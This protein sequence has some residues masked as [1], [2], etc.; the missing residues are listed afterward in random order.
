MRA[1]MRSAAKLS[2]GAAQRIIDGAPADSRVALT[3]RALYAAFKAR[4]TER[5]RRAPLDLDLP[6]RKII[7]GADGQVARVEKR[8]R[9]DA[10]RLI[11]EFMI[12]ANIAAAETLEERRVA[13][14]YRV[15]DVPDAEKLGALREYLADLG[16]SLAAAGSVRPANF[17][18]ILK[19][20][21][22]RG[23]KEMISE[24]V[25]R[26][27]KQAIYA[28]DNVGHFGLNIPR[29]AHFTSPIRRYADLTVHRALVRAMR[30]G[31][32]AQTEAEAARLPS[33]AEKISDFERRAM[34]A[35]RESA[36]RYLA[37]YHSTRIGA[38]FD[39][40]IRGVTRFGLF[41][42]LDE[43]GADGFVP[44]AALGAERFRF[45][46]ARHSLIGERTGGV[47]RLGQPVRVRLSSAAPLT[48]GLRFEMVSD[49]F[50]GA[51]AAR[52]KG[53]QGPQRRRSGRRKTMRG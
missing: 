47:Y 53:A 42:A 46:E 23:E 14:I 36:D 49:P 20:A 24:V 38:E 34:A 31:P 3:V 18:Q 11:E 6:E 27:Q 10:H 33:I 40:R 41:V 17:N 37:S 2:Y 48:G 50:A 26:A 30:F 7:L 4:W 39:G 45:V 16:Y 5:D 8:E 35:E 25:L 29:Y 15:H 52:K 21:E 28:T 43:T 44:I 1:L 19:T 51:P 12:L 9:L 13:R 22:T 32:G